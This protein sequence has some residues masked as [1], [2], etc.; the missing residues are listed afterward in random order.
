MCHA[1]PCDSGPA[2]ARGGHAAAGRLPEIVDLTGEDSDTDSAL[3]DCGAAP[4]ERPPAATQSATGPDEGNVEPGM[5]I[6]GDGAHWLGAPG[7]NVWSRTA[8]ASSSASSAASALSASSLR[9][10][11]SDPGSSDE[12]EHELVARL[13]RE[14]WEVVEGLVG[15]GKNLR[16]S[17][18]SRIILP[19]HTPPCSRRGGRRGVNRR[20]GAMGASG[21]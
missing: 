19:H 12:L 3:S 18:L 14:D 10:L 9:S 5:D 6:E 21:Q 20:K 16:D 4:W 8:S 7:G 11:C 15:P 1:M 13:A 17:A 2:G